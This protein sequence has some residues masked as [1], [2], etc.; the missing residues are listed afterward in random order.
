MSK[1]FNPISSPIMSFNEYYM[2]FIETKEPCL[3]NGWGWFVDI[4]L[5]YEQ[6]KIIQRPSYNLSVLKTIKEYP[7]IRSMKS[8]TNLHDNLITIDL[9]KDKTNNCYSIVTNTIGIIGVALC[10]FMMGL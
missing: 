8:M 5:N 6:S 7:S 1:K 4:E 3:E 10:C 9:E 2:N